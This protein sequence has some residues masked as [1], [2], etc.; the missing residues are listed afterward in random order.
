VGGIHL[1]I[2]GVMIA[3]NAVFAAFELALA[4]V[5]V[6]RLK[7]LAS[8]R[9]AGAKAALRMKNRMEASLAVVQLGITFVG[10]LAAAVGGAGADE[11]ISPWLESRWGLSPTFAD[12]L[13][14][15][16][17]VVPL[18]AVTIVVGELVPKAFAIK[19]AEWVCRELSPI[20]Q[21]FA[22]SVYPAVVAFEW[23]TKRFVGIVERMLNRRH[24]TPDL[25]SATSSAGMNELLADARMLR[26]QRVISPEQERVIV[27]A[28]KLTNLTVG[29][30]MVPGS[31]IRMLSADGPLIEHLVTVHLEA[32]TRFL[33]TE[34]PGDPQ[35]IIGYVN[36]KDLFFLA[37]THPH[38]PSLREIVR[39]LLAFAPDVRIGDALK[40][41]LSEHLHLALVRDSKRTVLGMITLEDILEEVVGDIQDEFD[42]LPRALIRS[43]G[44]W[45]AGGGVSVGRIREALERPDFGDGASTMTSLHEWIAQ[46]TPTVSAGATVE[47][48]GVRVLVRKVRR[49]K[50]MEVVIQP[51]WGAPPLSAAEGGRERQPSVPQ[52]SELPANTS[53]KR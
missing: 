53:T 45:I 37:K 11:A 5:S 22:Y 15:A 24:P 26:M 19:H 44:Q 43:G 10:A 14:L 51:H 50:I 17:V 16:L 2:I 18:G 4:S 48:D 25:G 7:Q 21:W 46:K 38:N 39:P 41:M 52:R 33:V 32:H 13:A 30:I 47:S 49:H 3:F 9:R 34:K 6:E 35:G 40:R 1:L 42:R 36:V 12:V 27:G 23:V 8:E 28:E 31:D 29:D 20:M